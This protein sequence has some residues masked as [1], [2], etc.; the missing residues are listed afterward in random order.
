M[1]PLESKG[2]VILQKFTLGELW[3][4]LAYSERTRWNKPPGQKSAC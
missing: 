3:D 2:S 4:W 1:L